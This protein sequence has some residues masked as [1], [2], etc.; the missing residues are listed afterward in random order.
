MRRMLKSTTIIS[1]GVSLLLACSNTPQSPS[2]IQSNT[3]EIDTLTVFIKDS[4]DY[5]T[6][7]WSEIDFSESDLIERMAY[8]DSANFIGKKIYPCA[9]CFLRPEAAEALE[10][11]TRI[12]SAKGLRLIIFDCYRPT[13]HQ[14]EMFDLVG[15]PRY[16]AEPKEGGSMHNKGL[17]VDIALADSTGSMLDFGSEFDDFSERSHHAYSE[18]SE[19]AKSNRIL[20]K[21]IMNEAGFTPYAHEWWHYSFK[22][23]NYELDDFIWDC[24]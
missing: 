9:R 13:K 12:A 16:V 21:N 5:D 7:L 11:A 18:L 3:E 22:N 24:N 4:L 2:S 1:V 14:Q 17:A 6:F 23:A 10:L 19:L 8:A 15:D 20:L